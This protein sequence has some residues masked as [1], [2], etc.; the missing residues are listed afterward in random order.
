MVESE[1]QKHSNY[2]IYVSPLHPTYEKKIMI[3][4]ETWYH[5]LLKTCITYLSSMNFLI[6]LSHSVS[7]SYLESWCETSFKL[8]EEIKK[9]YTEICPL[10]FLG[11]LLLFEDHKLYH[12]LLY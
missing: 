5:K 9:I 7:H 11:I 2:G 4:H 12:I 3:G 1:G 6:F 10:P 8:M